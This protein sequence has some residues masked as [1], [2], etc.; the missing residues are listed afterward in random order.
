M[1]PAA[2]TCFTVPLPV[3]IHVF[4]MQTSTYFSAILFKRTVMIN[5]FVT[6]PEFDEFIFLFM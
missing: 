5:I 6:A 2:D 4:S 3:F 1:F